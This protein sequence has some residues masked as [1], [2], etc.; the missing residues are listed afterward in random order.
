MLPLILD[1]IV[2]HAMMMPETEAWKPKNEVLGFAMVNGD[3]PH[4]VFIGFAG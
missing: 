2:L 1:D 3:P 4:L